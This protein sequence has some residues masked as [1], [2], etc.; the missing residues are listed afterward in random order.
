[1]RYT[2]TPSPCRSL[3]NSALLLETKVPVVA[4]FVPASIM[5]TCLQLSTSAAEVRI[6]QTTLS[7]VVP[8]ILEGQFM[9]YYCNI[10]FLS[11]LTPNPYNTPYPIIP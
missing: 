8:L 7:R 11:P 5:Q 10:I 4:K 3:A 6:L 1:M 9:G 2:L